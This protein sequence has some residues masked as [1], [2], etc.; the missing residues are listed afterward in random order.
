MSYCFKISKSYLN[1]PF[2]RDRVNSITYTVFRSAVSQSSVAVEIQSPTALLLLNS[3]AETLVALC[4][5]DVD[6]V[7]EQLRT[8]S[9]RLCEIRG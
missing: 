3:I 5:V 7:Q 6:I 2:V 4:A 9:G 1:M 8:E